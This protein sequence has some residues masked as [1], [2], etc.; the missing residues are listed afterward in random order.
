[1]I[2]IANDDGKKMVERDSLDLFLEEY[3]YVSRALPWRLCE[4]NRGKAKQH[5]KHRGTGAPNKRNNR[6]GA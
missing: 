5:C 2:I 6:V 4:R 3:V 1:V